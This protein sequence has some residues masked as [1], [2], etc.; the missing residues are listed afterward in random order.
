MGGKTSTSI[1]PTGQLASQLSNVANTGIFGGA[2]SPGT[3]VM[4]PAM[5]NIPGNQMQTASLQ[6]PTTDIA[7]A[8]Q[9]Q[10]QASLPSKQASQMNQMN[11]GMA[12]QMPFMPSHPAG[13]GVGQ[14]AYQGQ[15]Q[16]SQGM[17][18]NLGGKSAVQ[19]PSMAHSDLS[20]ANP[21]GT[22]NTRGGDHKF[23]SGGAPKKHKM[24]MFH[25]PRLATLHGPKLHTGPIHSKV[26]GRT[27]HLPMHVPSGSYVIPADII[28]SMGEGNT[29]A[30][31]EHMKRMF[32]GTPYGGGSTPYGQSG[33]PYG[34]EMPHKAY[35]GAA[36]EGVPIV[37]AG[38]EYVLSPEEVKYAGEGDLD[39][40][41]KALDE[42]VK[43]QRAKT[44]N[45]LKKLPGP[46]RD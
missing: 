34:A 5:P 4:Q 29:M 33:G 20:T 42:F 13:P 11:T 1:P 44:V 36:D 14:M 7:H 21:A 24:P 16:A 38:G 3:Q 22:F 39:A 18:T 9:S 35:G 46:K 12:Y 23:A 27:D 40:G 31:F 15:A 30:G 32:G 41:H 10:A 26:A 8:M 17:P 2:M 45:T 37:A 19:A 43:R 28:S 6:Q 25:A